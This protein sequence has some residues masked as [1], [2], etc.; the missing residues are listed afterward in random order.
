M[1]AIINELCVSVL[2]RL[3]VSAEKQPTQIAIRYGNTQLSYQ[4]LD[5]AST[6]LAN[7]LHATG[8]QQRNLAL[9]LLSNNSPHALIAQYGVWKAG[10]AILYAEHDMTARALYTQLRASSANT[11]FVASNRYTR[12]KRAQPDTEARRV[13]IARLTD[14]LSGFDKLRFRLRHER[15]GGHQIEQQFTDM[16]WENVLKLG[17]K[18]PPPNV[19]V[20]AET[21]ALYTQSSPTTLTPLTHQTLTANVTAMPHQPVKTLPN[22]LPQRWLAQHKQLFNGDTVTLTPDF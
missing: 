15:A 21:T 11:V 6:H 13:V 4:Q 14:Y 7:A 20:S 18:A 9:L 10:G 2:D 3:A 5:D 8:F 17:A 16:R 19:L 1:S 22:R 12:F